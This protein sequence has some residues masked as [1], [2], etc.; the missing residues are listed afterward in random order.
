[1]TISA[2]VRGQSPDCNAPAFAEIAFA[3]QRL[4]AT[5]PAGSRILDFGC[6]EGR[7]VAALVAAGFDAWGADI[8]IPPE[9]PPR[10]RPRLALIPQATSRLPY[11]DGEFDFAFSDQVFEHVE[12][13]EAAI[14]ELTRI[15]KPGALSV[16]RFPGPLYPIEGHVRMPLPFLCHSTA[17][18]ALWCALGLRPAGHESMTFTQSLA[19]CRLI[20]S[21]V[22]YRTKR[23]WRQIADRAG[24]TVEF[25]EKEES[26]W[27]PGSRLVRL[28]R[29]MG[30]LG[31]PAAAALAPFLQR[32]MVIRHGGA[33]QGAAVQ[34]E[35]AALS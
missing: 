13:A 32:Y 11:D 9:V 8:F 20:M 22:H 35:G 18:L 7:S 16:H 10:L 26:L 17:W 3:V 24:V 29:R 1:M 27:R 34:G 2:T 33:A 4:G 30:P 23:E 19:E 6:G 5:L 21:L 28:C 12:A 14:G 31:W 25:H 15:L